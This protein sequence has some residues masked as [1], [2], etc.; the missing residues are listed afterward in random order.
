MTKGIRNRL[1]T[2]CIGLLIL[3]GITTISQDCQRN[4]NTNMYEKKIDSLENTI[5][6]SYK[7]TIEKNNDSIK[8]LLN[9]LGKEELLRD[10]LNAEIK[11]LEIEVTSIRGKY[12]KY[13]EQDGVLVEEAIR[14]YEIYKDS[15][16]DD[17]SVL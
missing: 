3:I 2:I 16:S 11:E 17:K 10:T 7:K 5:E 9:L 15:T 14:R 8:V 6:N 12:D 1:I 4:D 13:I